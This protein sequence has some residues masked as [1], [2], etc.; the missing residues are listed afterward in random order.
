MEPAS[1]S[2]APETPSPAPAPSPRLAKKEGRAPRDM[3]LSLAVLLV[4]I[5]LFMGYYRVVLDGDQPVS[6]DATPAFDQAARVFPVARPAGLG[7][8][9]IVASASFRREDDGDT[10]RVGYVAPGGDAVQL[11]ESTV[12]AAAL[13]PAQLGDSGERLGNFRAEQRN[14]L[15]YS[16]RDGE[17]ALVVT[18]TDRTMIIL[19]A[20][21]QPESLQ[22]L[23]SALP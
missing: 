16:G 17:I 19:G 7:D 6:K 15:M 23:A 22:E 3:L 21:D 12:D 11:L 9:W 5:A 13:V 18:E 4:P 20:E 2:P 10:L 1:P 14:W 8:D